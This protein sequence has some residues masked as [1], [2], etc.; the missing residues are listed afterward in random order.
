MKKR[1]D[2]SRAVGIL[3]V[4][5]MMAGCFAPVVYGVYKVYEKG[6]QVILTVNVNEKPAV[7]YRKPSRSSRRGGSPKSPSAT[8]RR[9]SSPSKGV[10]FPDT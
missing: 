2:L 9:W 5:V 6:N 1:E 3:L 10:G 8:T 7:V 4:G